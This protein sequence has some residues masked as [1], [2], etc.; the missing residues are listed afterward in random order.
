MRE[1][2][3]D[4]S[5]TTRTDPAV[6]DL[7]LDMMVSD[8]GNPSSLHG[9]GLQAQIRMEE[10]QKQIA[11]VLGVAPE[12]IYFT[13]GGTE[14]DNT[15]I[16]GAAYAK[17]K[18]GKK[19][20]TTSF[21]HAAVLAPFRQLAEQGFSVTWID[22]DASGAVDPQQI[23]DAVDEQTTLVSVM[24]V[25]NEV[26]TIQSV[27][28]IAKQIKQKN[29]ETLIHCDAVQ[30]FGKIAIPLNK[31]QVDLMTFSGH[32]IHAPKGIGGLYIRKGVRI[33]PL[34]YGG[35]QQRGFRP[36]TESVPL[37]CG[38]G[39]AAEIAEKNRVQNY[40][41]VQLLQQRLREGLSAMDGIR[42][43]SPEDAIPYIVNCSVLGFRSETLLHFLEEKGI[44]VSSASACT[45]G[46]ASHVLT[47]MG[48]RH[49]VVDSALRISFCHEN[50]MEDVE[51]LLLALQEAQ[52]TLVKTR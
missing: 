11:K 10:A 15:A 1:I 8:Y 49:D 28:W 13:S 32:K 3:L 40:R 50:T 29:P 41:H 9:K 33:K 6:A 17:M 16:F 21:E 36:G 42:L 31:W 27:E 51:S 43:N 26:G 18:H 7:V 35:E 52:H 47:S 25:N 12:T 37:I 46:A 14:S 2:Y 19:L 24:L 23:V 45:K 44:Y 39:L 20:V 22:P 30:G 5:A 48:S 34:I 38:F 4:N